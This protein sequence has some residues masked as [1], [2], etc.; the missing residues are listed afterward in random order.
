VIE[1]LK[2]RRH[3]VTATT[4]TNAW[5]VL[6]VIDPRSKSASGAGASAGKVE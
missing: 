1:E 3:V 4:A 6:I 2:R 5:P